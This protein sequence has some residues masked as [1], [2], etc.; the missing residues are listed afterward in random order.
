MAN[1]LVTVL[2]GCYVFLGAGALPNAIGAL[3]ILG[4]LATWAALLAT[5]R[6]HRAALGLLAVGA[7]PFAIVTWWSVITR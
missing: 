1:G 6:S 4:G 7:L 2:G 3:G 5:R